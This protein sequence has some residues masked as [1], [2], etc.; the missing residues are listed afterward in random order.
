VP[1]TALAPPSG[2]TTVLPV[3][4]RFWQPH[5]VEQ[6]ALLLRGSVAATPTRAALLL[7]AAGSSSSL[8][9]TPA[10]ALFAAPPLTAHGTPVRFEPRPVHPP[11]HP[12]G[13]GPAAM[14]PGDARGG[15]LHAL[16]GT[17]GDGVLHLEAHQARIARILRL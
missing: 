6:L 5:D 9:G 8:P 17:A 15:R 7:L 16:R 3:P 14:P 11:T 13:A 10:R 4:A 12:P 1:A 2:A